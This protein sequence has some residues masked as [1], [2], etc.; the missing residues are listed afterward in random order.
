MRKS[1][2]LSLTECEIKLAA[3]ISTKQTRRRLTIDF[4]F[5]KYQI[6][7]G[8]QNSNW[9]LNEQHLLG[10]FV[11]WKVKDQRNDS[12][13]TQGTFLDLLNESRDLFLWS[14]NSALLRFKHHI[15]VVPSD[16]SMF[17][18]L[19]YVK[20]AWPDCSLLMIMI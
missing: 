14:D 17:M 9:Q 12:A 3:H 7:T 4:S 6:L 10:H 20:F 5:I 16:R 2:A 18:G 15:V 11:I 8:Y 13:A 19:F 1:A